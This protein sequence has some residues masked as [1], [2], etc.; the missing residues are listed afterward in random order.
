MTELAK[1]PEP[2]TPRGPGRPSGEDELVVMGA[3]NAALIG[4]ASVS[5]TVVSLFGEDCAPTSAERDVAIQSLQS[6]LE[7]MSEEQAKLVNKW[8][9]P[10]QFVTAMSSWGVRVWRIKSEEAS[11]PG[12]DDR[13]R[14]PDETVVPPPG[15][16]GREKVPEPEPV[17]EPQVVIDPT[18]GRELKM[19]PIE[20]L[21]RVETRRSGE[22]SG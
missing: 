19:I 22:S 2:T 10:V 21:G 1:K 4:F 20:Q 16:N 7:N 15:G 17:P 12:D 6:M 5:M 9:A 3:R 11:H 18:S 8:M 13:R 14:P